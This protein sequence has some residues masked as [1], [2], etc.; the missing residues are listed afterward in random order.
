MKKSTKILIVI[1]LSVVNLVLLGNTI[2]GEIF[3]R[4][5]VY[6][7]R[8]DRSDVSAILGYMR[9]IK[10]GV[11]VEWDTLERLWSYINRSSI[12]KQHRFEW[13]CL[14][15]YGFAWNRQSPDYIIHSTINFGFE[16]NAKQF[17]LLPTLDK[18]MFTLISDSGQFRAALSLIGVSA[19]FEDRI[20][21]NVIPIYGDNEAYNKDIK[22][23][24]NSCASKLEEIP[25][26]TYT[27]TKDD[28]L[29]LATTAF[30]G[31]FGR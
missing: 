16:G 5:G 2:V 30:M 18:N 11:F 1:V 6:Y 7:D 31:I 13:K 23:D 8:S 25:A 14:D 29:N 10:N 20:Y 24:K 19:I 22:F 9:G 21:A 3:P 27:L 28:T 15:Y 4:E 26:E 17:N 12:G